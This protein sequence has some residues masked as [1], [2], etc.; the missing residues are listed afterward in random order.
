MLVVRNIIIPALKGVFTFNMCCILQNFD[1][2]KSRRS[3]NP[4]FDFFF[5]FRFFNFLIETPG[6]LFFEGQAV[7]EALLVFHGSL[8]VFEV[9]YQVVLFL[10][11]HCFSPGEGVFGRMVYFFNFFSEVVVFCSFYLYFE[12]V[13]WAFI[14][15]WF[16]L[17]RFDVSFSNCQNIG[18]P[19]SLK[20][21]PTLFSVL[22]PCVVLKSIKSNW[23]PPINKLDLISRH[24]N[25]AHVLKDRLILV[26]SSAFFIFP[27][28]LNKSV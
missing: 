10:W 16:A 15:A 22:L 9:G 24:E 13:T 25:R 18:E 7:I 20:R 1:F 17:L 26:K 21:W 14:A 5:G 23:T 8:H 6:H 19:N 12:L 27:L 11:F 28:N 4:A 2:F 3:G